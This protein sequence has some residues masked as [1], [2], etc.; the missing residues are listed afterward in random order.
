MKPFYCRF[1]CLT[2]DKTHQSQL[3]QLNCWWLQIMKPAPVETINIFPLLVMILWVTGQS[4]IAYDISGWVLKL[5]NLC[6]PQC[7]LTFGHQSS[8]YTIYWILSYEEQIAGWSFQSV[9]L[10][11]LPVWLNGHPSCYLFV[12]GMWRVVQVWSLTA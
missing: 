2:D 12:H 8:K 10:E 1:L 7:T 3:N 5:E 6:G 4:S 9:T 11:V